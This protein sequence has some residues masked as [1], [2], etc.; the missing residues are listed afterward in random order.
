[1]IEDSSPEKM[2]PDLGNRLECLHRLATAGLC[3]NSV[4]HDINNYLG[5]IMSYAELLQMVELHDSENYSMLEK[6]VECVQSCS[7]LI[8]GLISVTHSK[9]SLATLVE[10]PELIN[11]TIQLRKYYQKSLEINMK[12]YIDNS[13]RPIVID[14][15]GIQLSLLNILKNAEDN[16]ELKE[17]DVQN[18]RIIKLTCKEYNKGIS[19]SIKDNGPAISLE[20]IDSIFSN[21]ITTKTQFHIGLGLPISRKIIEEHNGTLKYTKEDGFTIWIP[22]DNPKVIQLHK[23]K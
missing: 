3:I 15:P 16:L 7:T 11:T 18:P 14:L 12:K 23:W 17:Y 13:I 21:Y 22:Y 20:L 10:I 5:A 1:V 9:D 19:I 8:D 4:V 6:I 2:I